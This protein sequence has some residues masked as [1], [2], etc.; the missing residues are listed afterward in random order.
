MVGLAK[1]AFNSCVGC[2]PSSQS[3]AFRA[4]RAVRL[5][6]ITRIFRM[7]KH[8][9]SGLRTGVKLMGDTLAASRQVLRVW[10]ACSGGELSVD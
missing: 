9:A 1:M 10:R 8:G 3:R 7:N 6:R 5:S 2:R 4:L